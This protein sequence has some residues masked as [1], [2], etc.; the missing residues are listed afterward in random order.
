MAADALS[1]AILP[2]WQQNNGGALSFAQR[3]EQ[4]C[5]RVVVEFVHQR[6]QAA[7]FSLGKA[8]AR[9]PAEVM[10]GQVGDQAAFVFA[11][12]HFAGEQ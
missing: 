4:M 8:F 6:E 12:G 10:R 2:L 1:M 5:E 7:E 11:V 9:E 3:I